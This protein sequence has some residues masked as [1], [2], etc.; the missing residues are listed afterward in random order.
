MLVKHT[1]IFVGNLSLIARASSRLTAERRI[2]LKHIYNNNKYI[3]IVLDKNMHICR[4][5]ERRNE[6]SF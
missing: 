6:I 1:G 4:I 3:D 2:I 5:K